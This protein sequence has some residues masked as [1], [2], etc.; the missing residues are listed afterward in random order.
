MENMLAKL[1]GTAKL[2]AIGLILVG[3]LGL[4]VMRTPYPDVLTSSPYSR[5][6]LIAV[7]FCG[8]VAILDVLFS[9]LVDVLRVVGTLRRR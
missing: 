2:G 6:V 4:G 5:I 9:G 3:A 8:T 7:A 1:A